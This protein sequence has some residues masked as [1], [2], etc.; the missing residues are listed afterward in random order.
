MLSLSSHGWGN[1][2][3]ERVYL[4]VGVRCPAAASGLFL[5]EAWLSRGTCPGSRT[6]PLFLQW[7]LDGS[8]LF[9][10]HVREEAGSQGWKHVSLL[11]LIPINQPP[12]HE[13]DPRDAPWLLDVL[14]L[15]TP[16]FL[17]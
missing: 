13:P 4:Q 5:P 14:H 9:F 6:L 15:L 2:G 10:R 11:P 17:L 12:W 7:G 8:G 16:L 1:R 3:S